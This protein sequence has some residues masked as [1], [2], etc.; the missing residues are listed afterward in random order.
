[1]SIMPTKKYPDEE[2]KKVKDKTD[3]GRV[4]NMTDEET[5]ENATTDDDS[6]APTD[7]ELKKFKKVKK[8]G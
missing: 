2:L 4:N 6:K 7:E 8:N 3:Y 1:M 5:E